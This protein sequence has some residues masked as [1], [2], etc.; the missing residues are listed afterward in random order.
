MKT[1]KILVGRKAMNKTEAKILLGQKA[2]N[3]TEKMAVSSVQTQENRWNVPKLKVN[4]N[5]NSILYF[6][7]PNKQV[8]K[9]KVFNVH[10]N[11]KAYQLGMGGR[12]YGGRPGKSLGE[13]DNTYRYTVSECHHQ[14]DSCIKMGSDESH[15]NVS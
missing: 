15:F 5:A 10:R 2:M 1:A 13:G 9:L 14:N 6:T 11:H 12:V 4:C 3:K 7:T 8:R